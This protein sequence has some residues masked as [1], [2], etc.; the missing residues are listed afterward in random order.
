MVYWLLKYVFVGPLVW[1]IFRPRVEGRQ[2]IPRHG[3]AI[4]AS[5]HLSFSDSIFM[6]LTVPRRVTFVAKQEYFTGTGLKGWLIRMFFVNTG[7][8]PVDRSGGQ[9]AQAASC[10]GSTPRAPAH[11]TGGSTAARPAWPGWP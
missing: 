1:L 9:A 6:P 7:C 4:I 5:N 3:A 11:R 10:S 8:I 2:Y